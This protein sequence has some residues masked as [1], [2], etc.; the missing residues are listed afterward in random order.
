VKNE[1]D[2]IAK[3]KIK[4]IN[5][6]APD[7]Y[8]VSSYEDILDY[9]IAKGLHTNFGSMRIDRFKNNEKQ[10]KNFLFRI[11]VDGLSERIRKIINKPN[12]NDDIYSLITGLI[13]KGF[14]MFK[15]FMIF[16]YYFEKNS[17]WFEF[18]GLIERIKAFAKKTDKTVFLRIKFTPFIPNPL[19]P[20]EN[21]QPYYNI[22]RRKQI[23]MFFL[24]EK[25]QRSN[26][27]I[28]NDGILE[29]YS[30]YS[31]VYIS[32]GSYEDIDINLLKNPKRFNFLSENLVKKQKL[33]NNIITHIPKEKR[34]KTYQIINKR[35]N[36]NI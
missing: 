36:E 29:P 32:R 8:S 2:Y 31:Q 25:Y 28:I 4:K 6:F 9:I 17:D 30:Y 16:S 35:I 23:D 15:M 24:N 21:I 27:V 7:D 33:Y 11:G 12:S 18:V 34:E 14:V 13:E 26:V 5:I 19:T 20:L 22:E 10:N 3:D 1:I